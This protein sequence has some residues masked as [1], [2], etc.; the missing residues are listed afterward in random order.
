MKNIAELKDKAMRSIEQAHAVKDAADNAKRTMTAEEIVQFD[1]HMADARAVKDDIKREEDLQAA[2]LEFKNAPVPPMA[3]VKPEDKE[4]AEREAR[5]AAFRKYIVTGRDDEY[6]QAVPEMRTTLQ[7]GLDVSGG[8]I[9]APAEFVPE[10]I[11]DMD[12][13]V[14]I[15]RLATVRPVGQAG[16]LG[17]PTITTKMSG[18]VHGTEIGDIPQM[19]EPL[20]GRREWFPHPITGYT[21]LSNTLMRKAA[22]DPENLLREEIVR[23]FAE[24]EEDDFMNGTGVNMS[25]GVF[26]ASS[27]GID[28][29]R[30]VSAGNAAT[31]IQ[32][33]G[34]K[35]AKYALKQ[36]YWAKAVWMFHMDAV[37]QID[38]L[39]DGEGRYVW[40]ENIQTSGIPTLIG[41]PVYTSA[42]APS[43]FTASSYVGILGDFSNYLIADG[44]ALEI[45]RLSELKALNDL[46]VFLAR[47]EVDGMPKKSE[48]FA[49]VKLAAS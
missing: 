5:K 17:Y 16:S 29:D 7:V 3:P 15:R 12:M 30:D 24:T 18:A 1:K 44:L 11:K 47:L 26:V 19:T 22:I 46:T 25:L 10:I 14:A 33:D 40:N 34:L 9:S 36:G 8:Y 27:K 31:S 13:A 6:R 43:T 41:F 39:K 32:F 2:E 28:T 48:A 38:K 35:A 49:R 37:A 42:W 21:M 23:V 45:K 4:K 20:F